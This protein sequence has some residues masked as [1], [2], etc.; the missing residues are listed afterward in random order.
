MS[1]ASVS[2]P[3]SQQ[4]LSPDLRLVW[5]F[6]PGADP[7]AHQHMAASGAHVLIQDLEDFT[8]PHLRPQ[9]RSLAPT[10]FFR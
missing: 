8:P 1:E 9:A 2:V 10:S 3:A 6:G 4:R 7:T 5:L